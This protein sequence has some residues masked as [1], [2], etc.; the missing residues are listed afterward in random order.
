MF[1]LSYVI[2]YV[3]ITNGTQ[4]VHLGPILWLSSVQLTRISDC[5]S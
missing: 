1:L 2:V 4:Q 3:V 5:L